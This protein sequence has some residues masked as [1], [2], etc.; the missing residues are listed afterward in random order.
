MV[1]WSGGEQAQIPARVLSKGSEYRVVAGPFKDA[2]EARGAAGRLK[3][4]L[5]IDGVIIE[6]SLGK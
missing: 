5:E 2:G 1:G 6:P 3:F 4:D